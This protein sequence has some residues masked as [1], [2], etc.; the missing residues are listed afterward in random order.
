MAQFIEKS[1][2]VTQAFLYLFVARFSVAQDGRIPL[3]LPSKAWI[4]GMSHRIFGL[5]VFTSFIYFWF[6]FILLFKTGSHSNPGW[7]G[8]SY[9]I[10][11]IPSTPSCPPASVSR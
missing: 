7:C 9:Y 10:S 1:R 2:Q 5:K 4:T 3:P 11:Q 6:S 8:I